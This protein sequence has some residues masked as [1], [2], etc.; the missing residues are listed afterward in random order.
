MAREPIHWSAIVCRAAA[1]A[2]GGCYVYKTVS[3]SFC[4]KCRKSIINEANM[5]RHSYPKCSSAVSELICDSFKT[6]TAVYAILTWHS[7]GCGWVDAV[8][9]LMST[10]CW[11]EYSL[12]LLNGIISSLDVSAPMNALRIVGANVPSNV[13]R[14]RLVLRHQRV[15][16]IEHMSSIC[17]GMP[18][19]IRSNSYR[20]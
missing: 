1:A 18:S 15:Q 12:K 14:S 11:S 19:V 16:S 13:L 6:P 3:V 9:R 8:E 2:A 17:P 7:S 20:N 5:R 4:C 10:S